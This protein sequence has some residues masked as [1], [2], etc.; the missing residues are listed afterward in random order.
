M[1]YGAGP[2][3]FEHA[4]FLREHA[5]PTER[6]LWQRIRNNQLGVKFRRQHPIGNYIADFYCHKF[7]LVIELDGKYHNRDNQKK[8]DSLRDMD[9]KVLGIKVLRFDD[10]DV[11][12]DLET[13][14]TKIKK[15]IEHT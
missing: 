13:V 12:N 6:M 15:Y 11:V 2:S 5:T 7:K 1:H 10:D 4:R 9:M 3:I 8:A 14:I